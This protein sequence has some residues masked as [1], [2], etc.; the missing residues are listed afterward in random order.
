MGA[1]LLRTGV[2]VCERDGREPPAV[3]EASRVLK[4]TCVRNAEPCSKILRR[5]VKHKA[6]LCR[7]NQNIGAAQAEP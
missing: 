3:R 2:H 7:P 4:Q 1:R 6:V 5:S